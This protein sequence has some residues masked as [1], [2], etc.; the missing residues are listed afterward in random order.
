MGRKTPVMFCGRIRNDV[1]N[2]FV[3]PGCVVGEETAKGPQETNDVLA[4]YDVISLEM[5]RRQSRWPYGSAARAWKMKLR[6]ESVI[7]RTGAHE[8]I[9]RPAIGS[10]KYEFPQRRLDTQ[11]SQEHS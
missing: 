8:E 5:G 2:Y 1:Q 11:M 9:G 4:P 3:I 6:S 7:L 10:G